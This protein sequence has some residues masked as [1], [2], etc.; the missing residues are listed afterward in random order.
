MSADGRVTGG[1]GAGIRCDTNASPL[2]V[3]N[4]ITGNSTYG[5]G[6]DHG[7]GIGMVIDASPVYRLLSTVFLSADRKGS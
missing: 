3:D 6:N 4:M 7:A 1:A 2:I 5:S